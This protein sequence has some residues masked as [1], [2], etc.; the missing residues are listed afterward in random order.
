MRHDLLEKWLN[1]YLVRGVIT[2]DR[3]VGLTVSQVQQILDWPWPYVP[4]QGLFPH[5]P[6][7]DNEPPIVVSRDALALELARKW[8]A[9]ELPRNP[10]R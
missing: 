5:E 10:A 6:G 7:V 2:V 1:D 3:E 4:V 9:R 8:V